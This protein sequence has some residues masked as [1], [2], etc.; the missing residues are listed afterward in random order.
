MTGA[1]FSSL[2]AVLQ[3]HVGE[4]TPGLQ[5]VVVTPTEVLLD[6]ASGW[7]DIRQQ[8]SMTSATTMMA[9][10]MT[11]TLTAIAVLQLVER[12]QLRLSGNVA[13]HLP[14]GIGFHSPVTIQQLLTHTSGLPNP[15]PLRWVHLARYAVPFDENAA[16]AEVL[17][18]HARLVDAPGARFRY[19]NI[20]YWLLGKVIE[21]VTQQTFAQYVTANL[22]RPLQLSHEEIGFTIPCAPGHA[23]GYVR[24]FSGLHLLGRL[25]TGRELWDEAE[26][27]WV[28]LHP[29]MV[30]GPAFGG[31]VGTAR[32]FSRFLQ[33]QL[34]PQ[35]VLLGCGMRA[36]LEA[37]QSTADGR[38]IPMTL[39][40]HRREVRGEPVLFK[41]G[42]GGGFHCEMRLYPGRQLGAVVMTNSTGSN[43]R[44]LLD[45]LALTLPVDA[46]QRRTST[47][48]P[49]GS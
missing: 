9:Y 19:S 21:H 36:L 31:L 38:S 12:Q 32:A 3:Q 47:H 35:S 26:G 1:G 15:I 29:H 44:Q 49:Q 46:H 17:R 41:E 42:G 33:D 40:W 22:L 23:A 13:E 6:H 48:S 7:A 43:T 4:S 45:E 37:P 25:L 30:N 14:A 8:R 16:L 10:S 11:K 34:R 18:R 27:A 39:G 28:R 2:E 5:V 24:R 20:G